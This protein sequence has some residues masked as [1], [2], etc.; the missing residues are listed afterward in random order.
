M[1]QKS[2]KGICFLV[3]LCF[4]VGVHWRNGSV[5]TWSGAFLSAA[6]PAPESRFALQDE[7]IKY[8]KTRTSSLNFA[9]VLNWRF[10]ESIIQI[11]RIR[12]RKTSPQYEIR[13]LVKD[14][15]KCSKIRKVMKNFQEVCRTC[16]C[17]DIHVNFHHPLEVFRSADS[18]K[19]WQSSG[20]WDESPWRQRRSFPW[21][22]W[23]G[24]SPY[25]WRRS[26]CSPSSSQCRSKKT[27]LAKLIPSLMATTRKKKLTD[28]NMLPVDWKRKPKKSPEAS[29]SIWKITLILLASF[30]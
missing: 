8:F 16:K 21:D 22:T 14:R 23:G 18:K 19:S 5:Q 29:T 4:I 2:C 26:E 6:A 9:C 28:L 13:L 7:V 3:F 12:L 1:L 25:S 20:T 11:F 10:N 27:K 15:S 17:R 30:A 24:N